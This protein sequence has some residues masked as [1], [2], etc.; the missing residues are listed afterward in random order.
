MET[1]PSDYQMPIFIIGMILFTAVACFG[2]IKLQYGFNFIDEGYHA[3]ESWRLAAGDHFLQDKIT[4]ALAHYTLIT[5]IIFKIYPDISLLQLRQI[6]FILTLASLL[7][8]SVAL[9]RQS[10]QYAWLP[11]VFSLFAF[12]GL[13]PVGMISNLYYQTYP[14]LFLV[15]YL[16]FMLFGF[17]SENTAIKKISYVLSGLCLWLMS[18]SLLHLGLIILSPIII[19]VLSRKFKSKDYPFTSKDL[20]Y[21]LFPFAVCWILFLA[22]FNKSY[23]LNIFDSL[24]VVLSMPSVSGGLININ[25]EFIKQITIS[26]VFL[27][28]FF[29]AIKK[30]PVQFF[31]AGCALLSLIIFLIINTSLFVFLV[32]YYKGGFGKP[33]WFSS[34]L[35]SFTILFWMHTIRKYILKK[36]F[37]KEEELSIILMVPFTICSLTMGVFS[38]LGAVSVAQS[39]IPSVVAISYMLTS[40]L[41]N[42]RYQHPVAIL[43]LTLLLGPFYYT[44]ARHDWNFTFFDVQPR[45]TNVKIETGFGRG[46]YTNQVYSKLYDW[47]IANAKAFTQLDD[48]AISY[49]VSPMVHMITRLRPSLDDTFITFEKPRSYYEKCIKKMEQR[50]REPKIAFIFELKLKLFPVSLE[51]GTVSISSKEFDFMSSPDPISNYVKTHM[52]PASTF[53]I[54][55]DH[56][57]RCYVD[58][59]LPKRSENSPKNP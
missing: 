13:D 36:I 55:K 39:A 43:I 38:G 15:L 1:R 49:V 37:S 56:I 52:T 54:S 31:T 30:L 29:V 40:Q 53:K 25:W 26:M 5:R 6:Q 9:F 19:L 12:T 47:L 11:F 10:R 35:M 18:L 24:D 4:G 3:T 22:V 48:Y 17:Q 16:S 42:M 44:T 34:L 45:L 51:Q 59:N 21:V 27:S 23:L 14:H 57:I 20:L 8:F 46:I 50:G 2:W 7:I 32:P 58:N 33:M 41:K 28:L